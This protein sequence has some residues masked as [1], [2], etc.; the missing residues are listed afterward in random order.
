MFSIVFGSLII[1]NAITDIAIMI[2]NQIEIKIIFI[3]LFLLWLFISYSATFSALIISE[4]PI[5]CRYIMIFIIMYAEYM[6][7]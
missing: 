5:N 2:T 3:L 1:S 4:A 6:L 7:F